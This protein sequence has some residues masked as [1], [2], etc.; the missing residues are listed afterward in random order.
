VDAVAGEGEHFVAKPISEGVGNIAAYRIMLRANCRPNSDF[1]F[2]RTATKVC[3]E[4]LYHLRWQAGQDPAPSCMGQAHNTPFG[5]EEIDGRTVC[6][7]CREDKRRFIGEKTICLR[8]ASVRRGGATS[9]ICCTY[10]SNAAAMNKLGSDT[11]TKVQIQLG[12]ETTPVA[13][14]LSHL[15][16]V[17]GHGTVPPPGQSQNNAFPIG[18]ELL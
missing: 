13:H 11:V 15:M 1:Q 4:C 2:L 7:R 5:A 10:K 18:Q 17:K 3:E 8:N 12:E 9:P 14:N 6:V 16:A